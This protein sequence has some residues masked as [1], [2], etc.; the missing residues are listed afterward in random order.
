[1]QG[2]EK[3]LDSTSIR[4]DGPALAERLDRDGYLFIRQLLPRDAV[5]QVRTRLLKKAAEGGWLDDNSLIES[6]IANQDAACKDPEEQ[7]MKVFRSL[8]RDEELHRLRTH[9]A[10][11]KFFEGI[12]GEPALAHPS[13]VQRNIFPQ[14]EDFDFTTQP[15]QDKVH[16]GGDTNYAMWVPI[17]DCPMEKG[18]LAI[19]TGSHRF[20]VLDTK[21]G[22]GAG[23]MDISVPIPGQWATDSFNAGDALIFSDETVHQALPNHTNE[24]RQSFDARYQPAS[25]AIADNQ[26]TPYDGT[27]SWEEIYSK[28]E[29]MDQQYY[30]RDFDLEIVPLDRSYYE[31]RDNMAFQ[32]AENGD[33]E[34]RDALLRIVQRD[35]NP[36]KIEKAQKLLVELDDGSQNSISVRS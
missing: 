23:G 14:R 28:W 17:G 31:I 4:D 29:S 26:L 30:W 3:F 20:G 24:L 16:I 11:L 6:G 21:V 33:I 13:L 8:W 2:M 12:F 18:S 22:T 32:M 9:P 1:M 36:G 15:H 25:H 34:A 27:G 5:M 19:A 35:K 7:Y 10:V